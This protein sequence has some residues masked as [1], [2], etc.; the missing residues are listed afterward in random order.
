M[1]V[2]GTNIHQLTFEKGFWEWLCLPSISPDG[3]K[4]IFNKI[5][6]SKDYNSRYVIYTMDIG[7]Q[8]Y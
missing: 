1:D 8:Q 7:W 2:G 4:I 6:D 5:R 3:K